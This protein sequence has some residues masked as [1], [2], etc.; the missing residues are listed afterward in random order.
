[1]HAVLHVLR[2]SQW[3]QQAF[4]SF[5]FRVT[6]ALFKILRLSPWGRQAFGVLGKTCTHDGRQDFGVTFK[7]VVLGP[8]ECMLTS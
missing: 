5:E 1:M 8:H 3:D 2:S 6:H 7:N 4:V